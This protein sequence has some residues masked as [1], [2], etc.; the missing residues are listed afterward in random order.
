MTGSRPWWRIAVL[1]AWLW[2]LVGGDAGAAERGDPAA[3]AGRSRV[4][5]VLAP[6]DD[7]R[8][9]EQARLLAADPAGV[10]ERNLVLVAPDASEGNGLRRRYG[11]APD[12]FAVLLI[13]KDGGVKLRSARPLALRGLFEAID[14]MPMRRAEMRRQVAGSQP[15]S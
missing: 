13:G 5:L 2:P 8:L 11:V 14:A 4:L 3:Y 7:A 1:S 9:A 6:R 15:S 12:A 10:T